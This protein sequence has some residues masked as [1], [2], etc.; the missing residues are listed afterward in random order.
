MY[1][2]L[3]N[4]MVNNV[5]RTWLDMVVE[6]QRVAHDGLG[7][8]V[9]RCLGVFCDN[10]GMVG[11]HN[12]KWLQHAMNIPVRLFRRYGLAANIAKSKK[13]DMPEQNIMGGDVGG[14]HSAEFHGGGRLLP[15]ETLK[16]DIMPK[17]WSGTHRGVHDGI[18]LPYARD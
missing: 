11:S 4:M 10:D 1:L 14:G 12:S 18:L 13:N 9:G 16:A 6:D 3:F 8:T 7:E 2:M 17:V 15:I 5:I